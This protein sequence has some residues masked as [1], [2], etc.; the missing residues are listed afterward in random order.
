MTDLLN[1][2]DHAHRTLSTQQRCG[3]TKGLQ[4]RWVKKLLTTGA[5]PQ[6]KPTGLVRVHPNPAVSL[7]PAAVIEGKEDRE[8]TS[9]RRTW[10][11]ITSEFPWRLYHTINRQ[12]VLHL[13]PV[14][15][16]GPNGKRNEWHRSAAEAAERAMKRLG[17][18]TASMS[19]GAYEISRPTGD[20]PEPISPD[21][22]FPESSKSRSVIASWTALH[23]PLVQRLQG[24]YSRAVE[25]VAEWPIS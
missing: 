16:P 15:M 22:A 17:A 7:D 2:P 21:I 24:G 5:G 8:V 25:G 1:N 12:G 13:W 9:C 3:S 4:R 20:L 14:K 6:A 18:D 10:R 11:S 19:L 23:H